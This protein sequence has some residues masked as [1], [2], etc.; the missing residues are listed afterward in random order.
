M[1]RPP[2][3][4]PVGSIPGWPDEFSSAGRLK[5]TYG[6]SQ[7]A[8]KWW[9]DSIYK[10][11]SLFPGPF[12]EALCAGLPGDCTFTYSQ[13]DALTETV[14]LEM[15]G[16]ASTTEMIWLHGQ[17][18]MIGEGKTRETGVFVGERYQ[19]Q[20][21]GKRIA[22][23]VF[24]MA[25]DLGLSKITLDA[26]MTGKF[27]WAKL[28]F[29]PDHG[30]WE[31]KLKDGMKSKLKSLGRHIDD[32][33]MRTILKLIDSGTPATIRLIA[34]LSD[35]VPSVQSTTPDG[36]PKWIPLG[37]ALLAEADVPWYGELNLNDEAS[38]KVFESEVRGGK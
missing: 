16:I 32:R 34:N 26:R 28:G 9:N 38:K 29:L 35:M 12:A 2:G 20:G 25:L 1:A 37:V 11:V 27:F 24:D 36:R 5:F 14:K 22:A 33:R 4:I 3:T 17:E 6:I 13:I 15:S 18:I 30:S 7:E 23:N 19:A 10:R 31:F 8:A 21:I